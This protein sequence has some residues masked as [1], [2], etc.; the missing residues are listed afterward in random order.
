VERR[1]VRVG[2]GGDAVVSAAW[3]AGSSGLSWTWWLEGL[4]PQGAVSW[5]YP[6]LSANGTSL[7]PAEVARVDAYG[8]VWTAGEFTGSLA[9]GAPAGTLTTDASTGLDVVALGGGSVLSG[10]AVPSLAGGYVTDMALAP[11]GKIVLTGWTSMAAGYSG[12]LFVSK[13]GF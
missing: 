12:N 6:S 8:R 5:T 7:D 9:L 1:A 10:S 13:L 3:A 11:G 2:P 4:T